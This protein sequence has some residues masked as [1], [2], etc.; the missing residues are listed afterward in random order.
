MKIK[1]LISYFAAIIILQYSLLYAISAQDSEPAI[2]IDEIREN[3]FIR[4][5]VFGIDA[6]EYE[7]FKVIVYVHTDKWYIH[8][9]AAGGKGNCYAEIRGDGS[10]KIKT[11]KREF[12]ADQVAA[13]IVNKSYKP[14]T[15]TNDMEGIP[16][17]TIEFL[18][19][20][21]EEGGDWKL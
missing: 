5:E 2:S 13:L 18:D 19:T 14:P 9:Y 8:P 16:S 15:T 4:G 21:Y 11:V 10:W 20:E 12:P 6:S 3:K 1:A 7:Q 17:I